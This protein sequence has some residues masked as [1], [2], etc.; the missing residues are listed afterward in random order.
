MIELSER[1]REIIAENL[2]S[3]PREV[4]LRIKASEDVRPSVIANQI[5]GYQAIQR[6][7]PEWSDVKNLLFPRH[8]SLEQCS[9]S[10]TAQ[11]KSQLVEGQ[12]LI[13][14]TGGF[15]VDFSFMAQKFDQAIYVEQDA[16][17]CELARHNLPLLNVKN[18]EVVNMSAEDFLAQPNP[19]EATVL[20]IDPSRRDRNG[21]RKYAVED[22]T[23]N[24]VELE[25][26][27]MNQVV[28]TIIKL[29][30]MVDVKD[31]TKKFKFLN[32]IHIVAVE[33]ECKEILV[34]L[35]KDTPK[36][37]VHTINSCKNSTEKFDFYLDDEPEAVCEY[38][39]VKKY[40]YEPNSAIMK[41]GGFKSLAQHY[42]ICKLQINSHLYTSDEII[43]FPGRRFEV[44]SVETFSKKISILQNVNSAN[45]SV[46]NFPLSADKLRQKL[47]FKDGGN[48]YLFGTTN[49]SNQHILILCKRVI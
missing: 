40:L 15:G 17:L 9:S 29:S 39:D 45:I 18:F 30:P 12:L 28:T 48:D 49:Q 47:K 27:L 14:L 34:V 11:Y 5:A 35:K 23:P 22:C 41:S 16:E 13:D 19:S 32:S 36:I 21:R 10:A 26:L 37:K 43:N 2:F 4:A 20:F 33:G 7:I 46:R 6:K 3:D 8:V 24:V 1:E 44:V 31:L 25:Q 38:S 42:N